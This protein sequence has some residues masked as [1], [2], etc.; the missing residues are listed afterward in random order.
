MESFPEE[1]LCEKC[2]HKLLKSNKILHDLKCQSSMNNNIN[3]LTNNN[4]SNINSQYNSFNNNSFNSYQCPICKET[5]N[6]KDKTDHLLCHELQN[7]NN[8]NSLRNYNDLNS[9]SSEHDSD[10]LNFNNVRNNINSNRNINL[11]LNDNRNNLRRRSFDDEDDDDELLD[12][13]FMD[14][15]DYGLDEENIQAYPTSK[16]KDINKLTEDKK[17]CTICL[18]EYKN[19]DDSIILPCIHIFHAECIKKWMKSHK[20]C[21]ICKLKINSNN[22]D[23]NY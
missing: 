11:D 3:I 14:D 1:Y 8:N 18:E 21:P 12:D 16:I 13:E 6:I 17:K 22:I 2:G 20:T 19:N 10:R 4:N 15:D 5:M 7:E 23:L 9:N